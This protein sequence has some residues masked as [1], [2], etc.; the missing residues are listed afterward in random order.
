M[1]YSD[2]Q[3]A[4]YLSAK[5]G[6]IW[7]KMKEKNGTVTPTGNYYVDIEVE[8][9]GKIRKFNLSFYD[10]YGDN[11]LSNRNKKVKGYFYVDTAGE[12]VYFSR[13]ADTKE[14]LLKEEISTALIVAIMIDGFLV[15]SIIVWGIMGLFGI[16]EVAGVYYDKEN[17]LVC[18][19][20]TFSYSC[21]FLLCAGVS[22]GLVVL[23]WNFIKTLQI[24]LAV[25][26]AVLLLM[27]LTLA[28][29]FLLMMK[30]R[31]VIFYHNGIIFK[32]AL[33]KIYHYKDEEV[34]R[35]AVIH[36]YRNR[37]IKIVTNE[38]NIWLNSFC[39]NFNKAK[40]VVCK[41]PI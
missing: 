12:N 6:D 35:I 8:I 9:A 4:G 16:P 34:V 21:L 37:N 1:D 19:Y 10:A 39:T 38:K 41:Y 13:T 18:T 23:V 29:M 7:E 20:R 25:V 14:K 2:L 15:L 27:F 22:F 32:T 30:N 5:P 11:S 17:A 33:G 31:I 40:E 36:G 28:V 24:P 26:F 3:S